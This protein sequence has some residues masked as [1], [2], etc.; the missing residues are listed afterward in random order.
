MNRVLLAGL[1]RAG[2]TVIPCHVPVFADAADKMAG[3]GSGALSRGWR[4]ALAWI[5]LIRQFAALP[6][7]DVL[8]VGYVGHVDL[9]LA[10]FLSL[11]RR[12]P[13]VLNALISLHDTVVVDRKL[14]PQKSATAQLLWWLDRVALSLADR[15][16][17]DTRSHGRFLSQ[18]Y[19]VPQAKWLRVPVGADPAGLPDAPPP[20]PGK[21]PLTVLYF[22]TY[23]ALHGVPTILDAARRLQG[24]D[25]IRFVLLGR[26]Q[27]LA[28]AKTAA[29]DLNNVFFDERWVNRAELLSVVASADVVLGVFG[30]G[31]KAGRVVP[32]KV[33]DGLAMARPVITADSEAAREWLTDNRHLLLVPAGDGD[34]LARA[35]TRLAADPAQRARLALE[36]HARFTELFDAERIGTELAARLAE[37]VYPADVPPTD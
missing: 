28:A 9:F 35:I 4:L 21:T 16:L 22:G 33:F 30:K 5:R 3:V 17:I 19:R 8:V 12:R 14:V 29:A 18:K 1:A 2:V 31:G 26:G 24:R 15:V 34:A 36:G 11:F 25:D 27:E 13:V 6:D 37:L 23:I 32:C 7:Y 20:A 10:R